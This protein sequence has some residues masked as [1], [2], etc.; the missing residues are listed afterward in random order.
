MAMLLVPLHEFSGNILRRIDERARMNNYT[1]WSDVFRE[2]IYRRF[3]FKPSHKDGPVYRVQFKDYLEEVNSYQRHEGNY[4]GVVIDD[5]LKGELSKLTYQQASS[6]NNLA[7][8]AII[9]EFST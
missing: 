8:S 5:E 2:V 3:K 9:Q 1:Y 6:W 7:I 4:L